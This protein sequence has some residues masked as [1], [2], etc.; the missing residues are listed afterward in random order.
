MA[1]SKFWP[2]KTRNQ[3]TT[4]TEASH[5]LSVRFE[6]KGVYYGVHPELEDWTHQW[7]CF[8]PESSSISLL[9]QLEELGFVE[10]QDKQLFLAWTSLYQLLADEL[11]SSD[12]WLAL[13]KLPELT[14]YRPSLA[15]Q[16]SLEELSFRITLADWVNLQGD[17]LVTAPVVTGAVI[18]WQNQRFL[19]NEMVWRLVTEVRVFYALATEQRSAQTNRQSWSLI[20][21]YACSAQVPMADF[22]QRTV[23]LSPE[24]LVL[25]LHKSASLGSKTVQV[26]PDFDGAPTQWLDTFDK[27]TTIPERYDIPDGLGIIQIL[28]APQVRSVLQELRRWPGRYVSGQRA[29][30]FIRNPYAALGDDAIAVIDETQFE[31]AREA[32][33][34]EF[35]QFFIDVNCDDNGKV[36]GAALLIEST[37]IHS[38]QSSRYD[39]ADTGQLE[40]FINRFERR[41]QGGFQCLIWEGY[42][43]EILGD[44]EFQLAHLKSIL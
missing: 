28:I 14:D 6:N 19:L 25:H 38:Q 9:N 1:L 35:E 18:E 37:S 30:A 39:F 29:E 12:E 43:L 16:G 41:I 4:A 44:A 26:E 33:G 3:A 15:S 17:K 24:K 8:G 22:L 11:D 13:L 36:I 40:D 32:A 31:Q 2:L 7:Q 27:Y 20:R 5:Q 21:R 42:E 10:L 23:V 34:I